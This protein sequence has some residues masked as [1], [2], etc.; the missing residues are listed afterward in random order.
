MVFQFCKLF[1]VPFE[2]QDGYD[3]WIHL[4][5]DYLWGYNCVVVKNS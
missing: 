2:F 4:N 3:V 5:P 1:Q